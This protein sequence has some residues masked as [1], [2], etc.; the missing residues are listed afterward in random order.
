M[1]AQSFVTE[2]KNALKNADVELISNFLDEK[3]DITFNDEVKT[4]NEKDAKTA[5]KKIFNKLKPTDFKITQ[6]GNSISNNATFCI[7]EM[8]TKNENYRIY[9]FFLEKNN[10][11]YLKELRFENKIK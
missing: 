10:K 1:F 2:I 7:G 11:N 5:L 6:K 9:L 4:Y 3:I 8:K